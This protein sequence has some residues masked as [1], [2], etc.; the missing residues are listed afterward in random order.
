M[1]STVVIADDRNA[2][3]LRLFSKDGIV[4]VEDA[5]KEW[6]IVSFKLDD[7]N[8]LVMLRHDHVE[9]QNYNTDEDG[10]IVEVP[11]WDD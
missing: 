4:T 1:K 2:V 8:K 11:E 10:R 7:D 6:N 3:R 5:D 9:D